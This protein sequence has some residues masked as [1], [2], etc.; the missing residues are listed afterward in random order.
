MKKLKDILPG[1]LF[2][3][4]SV[5]QSYY[6]LCIKGTQCFVPKIKGYIIFNAYFNIYTPDVPY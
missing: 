2:I 6:A 3:I 5:D 1:Q 4:Q